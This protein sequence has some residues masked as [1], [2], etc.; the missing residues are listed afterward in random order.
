M[1][2][3][4]VEFHVPSG[5]SVELTF[6]NPDFMPHNIVFVEPG[7]T[8]AV[9]EEA[10]KLGAEGFNRAFVPD[11]ARIIAASGLVDYG[12]EEVLSFQAPA[13]PGKYE[14]VCTFPGHHLMMRGYMIVE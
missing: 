7:A 13:I 12:K 10:L 4:L 3:D 11:D 2:Y 14:F 6:F 5:K 9:A 8:D 1:Q